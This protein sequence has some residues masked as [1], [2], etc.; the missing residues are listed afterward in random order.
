MKN[1]LLN[2]LTILGY[3]QHLNYHKYI[4]KRQFEIENLGFFNMLKVI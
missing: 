1:T 4:D 2:Y 3:S